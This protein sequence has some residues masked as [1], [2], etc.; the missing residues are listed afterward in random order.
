[1]GFAVVANE[2]KTLSAQTAKATE[3]IRAQVDSV[4]SR[5]GFA[6]NQIELISQTISEMEGIV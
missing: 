5:T 4:Q 3:E 2:V 6:A 1:K